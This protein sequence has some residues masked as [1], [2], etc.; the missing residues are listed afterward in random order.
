MI[1]TYISVGSNHLSGD[2]HVRSALLFLQRAFEN[3]R[4]SS[5]YQTP[6]IST[7]DSSMYHNAVACCSVDD[8]QSAETLQRRLKE[9]EESAGRTHGDKEVLIDLDLVVFGGTIT[10]PV[11]FSRNYFSIGYKELNP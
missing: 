9:Y 8:S 5:V 10:R 4:C 2:E 3:V 7:G 11:D 6:S 1:E